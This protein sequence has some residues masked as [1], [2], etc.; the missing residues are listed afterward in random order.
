MRSLTTYYHLAATPPTR[1]RMLH[2]DADRRG[3]V[4]NTAVVS[5]VAP[6]YGGGRGALVSS[7]V[8]GSHDD[9]PSER[10]VRAQ[11]GLVYGTDAGPWEH[12]ATYAI[13]DAL[14]AM[15]P[16]LPLRRPVTVAEGLF[17]AGDHRDTASLQGALVSGRRAARAVHSYLG[18]PRRTAEREDLPDA[19]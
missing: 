11:L 12:V 7:T 10:A 17:V 6:A 2:L 5:N 8:L 18:L 1:S 13:D 4:V 9:V 15:L 14:P 19:R 3:P 16:P